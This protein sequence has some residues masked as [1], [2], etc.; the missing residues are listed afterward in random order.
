MRWTGA[1]WALTPAGAARLHAAARYVRA[2]APH[3]PRVVFTG[4]WPEASTG[5]APPPAGAREGDLMLRAARAAGLA[6]HADLY[7]ETRSRSTLENLLHTVE[8]QLLDG[9]AF[10]A[11]HPLG[12]VT[13]DWHL[14]R[15]RYLAGK[16][17]GLH[18]AALLDVPA[19]GGEQH[20]DR[21]A[22]LATR[23]GFLGARRG[24]VLRK[25]ERLM[26]GLLRRAATG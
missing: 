26:V 22:L 8:D 10:G 24:D 15:V 13:H 17:L 5:A 4:G 21:G 23:L 12:L 1:G 19:T 3:R 14:P 7:A 16:V 18:G 25:R 9:Y 2:H 20:D 6:A 11:A